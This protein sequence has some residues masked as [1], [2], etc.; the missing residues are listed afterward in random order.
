MAKAI[1]ICGSH[2]KEGSNSKVAA[3]NIAKERGLEVIEIFELSKMKI[4]L[5]TGA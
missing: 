3:I 2:R 5:C 4:K 1:I